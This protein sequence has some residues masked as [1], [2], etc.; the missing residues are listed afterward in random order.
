MQVSAQ[1]VIEFRQLS[2]QLMNISL[3]LNRDNSKQRQLDDKV[4]ACAVAFTKIK[5]DKDDQQALP[6][7]AAPVAPVKPEKAR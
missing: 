5:A 6:L 7:P 3:R 1:D 2:R 4:L